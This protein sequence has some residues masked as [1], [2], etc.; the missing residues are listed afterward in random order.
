[1][2]GELQA[3]TMRWKEMVGFLVSEHS[4][5]TTPHMHTIQNAPFL[6]NTVFLIAVLENIGLTLGIR[7][8]QQS[9]G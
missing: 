1:M 9:H 6:L 8:F 2:E 7:I 5:H 3:G 4:P